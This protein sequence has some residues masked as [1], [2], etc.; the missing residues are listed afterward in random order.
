MFDGYFLNKCAGAVLLA[1]LI[2]LTLNGA[3]YA[4]F[5]VVGPSPPAYRIALAIVDEQHDNGI[6]T[7]SLS[8]DQYLAAADPAKGVK[9][10]KKC[11]SCHNFDK[12]GANKI[13]PHLWNVIGRPV[14]NADGFSYSNGF[15]EKNQAGDRWDYKSLNDFLEN[16]KHYI[17][18]TKMSFRGLAKADQRADLLAYMREQADQPQPLPSE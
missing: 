6:A 9:V 15:V 2:V 1:F 4:L 12:G 11:V 13:G 18:G 17:P 7:P 10:A 3:S 14:A 8:L 5:D 16:P